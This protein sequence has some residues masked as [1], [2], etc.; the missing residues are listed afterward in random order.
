MFSDVVESV[1]PHWRLRKRDAGVITVK[2][3]TVVGHQCRCR[4]CF[5]INIPGRRR[6]AFDSSRTSAELYGHST[7]DVVYSNSW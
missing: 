3:P 7:M 2:S 4:E 5:T 6:V 1:A